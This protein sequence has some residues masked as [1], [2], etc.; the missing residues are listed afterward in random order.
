MKIPSMGSLCG[1]CSALAMTSKF[2]RMLDWSHIP[3][4]SILRIRLIPIGRFYP[5]ITMT[6]KNFTILSCMP[7][8]RIRAY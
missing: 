6:S 1:Y 3:I 2:R 4:R 7:V 5:R 8:E